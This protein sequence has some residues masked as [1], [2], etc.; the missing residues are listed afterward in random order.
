M[1]MD[2]LIIIVS[3]NVC[4]LIVK[5]IQ[6]IYEKV[7]GV[8]FEII[9]VDNASVDNSVKYIQE[10]FSGVKLIVSDTN[11]GFGKAN[12]RGASKAIG[13][14]LFFLNPDTV[15]VNDAVTELFLFMESHCNVALCGANLFTPDMRPNKSYE[16]SLHGFVDAFAYVL[17]IFVPH[18]RDVFNINLVPKPVS[19]VMGADMFMRR[20]VFE[21]I[22]R[23]DERYFMYFEELRFS[24]EIQKLRLSIYSVPSAS[25]IH[26]EGASNDKKILTTY[27]YF[28]SFLK[29]YHD[30]YSSIYWM[31]YY[32]FRFK[33]FLGYFKSKLSRNNEKCE[34]WLKMRMILFKNK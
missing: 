9:V 27:Y 1:S 7:K 16:M 34:Y 24:H 21:K 3:Y 13:R 10:K 22:G 28:D 15:L 30:Y 17:N 19:W 12:N 31:I 5:C 6:S 23:F 14:Y 8:T 33:I 4:N 2:V 26:Y 18:N 20:S 25:I 29:Y 32:L 11:L